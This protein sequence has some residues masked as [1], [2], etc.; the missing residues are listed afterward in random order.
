MRI[1]YRKEI[2][3]SIPY[4]L[5]EINMINKDGEYIAEATMPSGH[6]YT[7]WRADTK[8]KVIDFLDMLLDWSEKHPKGSIQIGDED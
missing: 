2:V 4:E 1:E 7:I 6:V 8:D 3:F 5:A